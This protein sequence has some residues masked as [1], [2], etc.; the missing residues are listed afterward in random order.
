MN[1]PSETEAFN[2][3]QGKPRHVLKWLCWNINHQCDKH[4]GNKFEIPDFNKI[5]SGHDI[6]CLQETKGNISVN[7]YKCYNSNRNDSNS[8]GVCIGIRKS[9][10]AGTSEVSTNLCEDMVIVKFKAHFFHFDKDINLVNVYNSPAN[11]SFKKRRQLTNDEPTTTLE[12]V[13]DYLADIPASEDIVLLGDFNART[14]ILSDILS[15][16][17]LKEGPN[18]LEECLHSYSGNIPTR[19]NN[20]RT[21]NSNGRPFIELLQTS[22]LVILNGRTIGDIFGA[23]TCIQR[24][25]VSTVDYICTSPDLLSNVR[26]FRVGALNQYSD[27]KPLSMGLSINSNKKLAEDLG[28]LYEGILPAPLPYKWTRDQDPGKDTSTK[29]R[30]AQNDPGFLEAASKL[31][32]VHLNSGDETIKFNSDI[33]KLIRSVADQVTTQKTGKA[34]TN[35]KKWFDWSCRLAKRSMNQ[36]EPKVDKNPFHK[37]SRDRYFLRKKEYRSICRAKKGAFLHEINQKINGDKNI[38]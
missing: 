25:G 3:S 5:I 32:S 31:M 4:G 15:D 2:H 35:K 19:N 27:H 11:G 1:R 20:D 33:T 16:C 28:R 29:F 6:F 38:N 23:P 26:F 37:F 7:G 8:G 18:N 34:R 12:H 14:G 17:S 9:I 21:L 22:G 30:I 24:N 13:S 10:A 36:L